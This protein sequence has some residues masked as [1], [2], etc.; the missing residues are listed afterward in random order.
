VSG[1]TASLSTAGL[2][3]GS[4]SITVVY[5]GD[6]NC[7]G[8]TSAALA[9]T[10]NKAPTTTAVSASSGSIVYG[11]NVNLTASVAPAAATG[12]VQFLDGTGNTAV[13]R[14]C[15]SIDGNEPGSGYARVHSGV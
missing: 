2:A 14:R 6:A 3:A 11:Q 7:N 9:Q 15:G 13:E 4:H 10:V 12:T 8:V 5:A 1:G